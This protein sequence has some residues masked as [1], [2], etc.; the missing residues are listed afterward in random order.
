MSAALSLAEKIRSRLLT[1][2][3]G[4]ELKTTVDLTQIDVIIDRQV[5]L[6]SKINEAIAKATGT[7]IVITWMGF[8]IPDKN[9]SRPRLEERFTI[10][11]WSKQI[12]DGINR[13]ADHVIESIVLRL[14][15]WVPDGGHAFGETVVTSG[16]MV[17]NASF[18][19]YDCEIQIPITL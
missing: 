11:V 12:I 9:T 5:P 4:S 1:A 3:S 15:H 10:S 13:P 18:L 7:A 16:D 6:V 2:P 8:Q 17:P 19:V 14:W